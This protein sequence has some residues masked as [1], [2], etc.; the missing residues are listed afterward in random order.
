[1]PTASLIALATRWLMAR[2]LMTFDTLGGAIPKRLAIARWVSPRL[3][4]AA[5][6]SAGCISQFANVVTNKRTMDAFASNVKRARGT[7]GSV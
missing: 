3:M 5:L 4:S 6:M 1:M 2:L 7:D